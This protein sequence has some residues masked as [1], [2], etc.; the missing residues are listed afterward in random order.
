MKEYCVQYI[1]KPT[2]GTMKTKFACT[3]IMNPF[4]Y[5]LHILNCHN[6]SARLYSTQIFLY[7]RIMP[8]VNYSSDNSNSTTSPTSPYL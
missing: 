5:T 6:L 1:L 3:D 4:W 8:I 7:R 2:L